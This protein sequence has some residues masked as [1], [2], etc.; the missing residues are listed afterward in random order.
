MSPEDRGAAT[1]NGVEIIDCRDWTPGIKKFWNLYKKHR[2]LKNNYDLLFIGF[3]GHI[4]VPF[5]KLISDKKIVFDALGSL[6][7]GIIM[8]RK[9]YGFLGWRILYVWL[10]DWLAFNLA[11][12]SLVDTNT[13]KKFISDKFFIPERKLI[14]L[15]TGV[16]D[17]V[18]IYNPDIKKLPP[19]TVLFRGAL[20]PES[21][22]EYM[23][24][25]AKIL[26]KEPVQFRIMGSGY[27][28]PLV[29][30]MIKDLDLKNVEWLTQRFSWE[31]MTGKMQECHLSLGQ[32]SDH[33]RQEFHV[34]F[35]TMESMALHIP[36]MITSNS[37]GIMEFLK[38][39]ETC[40]TVKPASADDLA[41]KILWA[42]NNP[43]QLN[44]VAENAHAL[45]KTNF[46]T[47]VLARELNK[48]L[49]SLLHS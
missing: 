19:F 45:F 4:L 9:K 10:V 40:L 38:D 1:S 31:E 34:P 11:D 36:Y 16:D 28:A 21:G 13:R 30:K 49:S 12:I 33:K 7:D 27:L 42:K 37:Y 25:A 14:R 24:E 26:E 44:Q 18:F 3:S 23:L 5:A 2:A 35:K 20:M 15:W 22:I 29:E 17:T 6:Y 47:D 41:K 39:N 48:I 32:L 46:T 43:D 8:S